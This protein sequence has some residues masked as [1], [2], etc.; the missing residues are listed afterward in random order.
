MS[1]NIRIWCQV[2]SPIVGNKVAAVKTLRPPI[3]PSANEQSRAYDTSGKA[4]RNQRYS[5]ETGYGDGARELQRQPP[6]G[7]IKQLVRG[8][9]LPSF[10]PVQSPAQE[11]S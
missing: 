3:T 6:P 11:N 5:H 10:A 4:Q 1:V 2:R 8:H 9:T 7:E